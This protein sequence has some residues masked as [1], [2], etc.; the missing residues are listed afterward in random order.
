MGDGLYP[1]SRRLTK[2]CSGDVPAGADNDIRLEFLEYLPDGALC[3]EE[4]QIRRLRVAPDV[5][6]RDMALECSPLW[7]RGG[8][9]CLA[10]FR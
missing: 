4:V 8:L 3:R 1:E 7:S 9:P 2:D 5:L 6:Y 10:E